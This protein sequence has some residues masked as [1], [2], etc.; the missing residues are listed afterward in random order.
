MNIDNHDIQWSELRGQFLH[1]LP[2]GKVI[3]AIEQISVFEVRK[4]LYTRA[5]VDSLCKVVVVEFLLSRLWCSS[6][7]HLLRRWL[8]EGTIDVL[9]R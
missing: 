8:C 9:V 3:V 1:L 5:R 2:G 7:Y 6:I 4:L